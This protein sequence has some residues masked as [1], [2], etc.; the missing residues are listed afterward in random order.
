MRPH[1]KKARGRF[2]AEIWGQRINFHNLG[3]LK[4]KKVSKV[5]VSS[6]IPMSS[7]REAEPCPHYGEVSPDK[8][9]AEED[10]QSI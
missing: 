9:G 8:D 7:L 3:F 5:G 1:L 6:E 2:C 10:G 4:K